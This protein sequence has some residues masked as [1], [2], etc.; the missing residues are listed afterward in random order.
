MNSDRPKKPTKTQLKELLGICYGNLSAVAQKTG[1]NRM[2]VKRWIENDKTGKLEDA[3]NDGRERFIDFA[4]VCALGQMKKG[5]ASVILKI[6]TT[7]GRKR[8]YVEQKCEDPNIIGN[9]DLMQSASG[10]IDLKVKHILIE[11]RS[12]LENVYD[13]E[14]LTKPIENKPIEDIVDAIDADFLEVDE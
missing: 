1:F 14:G 9:L 8:G 2:A 4:E 10:Q 12:D 11:N 3:L 6:L 13:G 5:N 7:L